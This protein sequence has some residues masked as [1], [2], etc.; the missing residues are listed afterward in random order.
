M[1]WAVRRARAD[2]CSASHPPTRDS[3]PTAAMSASDKSPAAR[4][5][6]KLPSD[7]QVSMSHCRTSPNTSLALADQALSCAVRI[8]K[9]PE[10]RVRLLTRRLCRE[11]VGAARDCIARACPRACTAVLPSMGALAE[12][13]SDPWQIRD[14]DAGLE[15]QRT[16]SVGRLVDRLNAIS[17]AWATTGFNLL[18]SPSFN[19]GESAVW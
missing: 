19:P 16:L 6:A 8:A 17:P 7:F 9:R 11:S 1:S 18:M 3:S 5:R 4:P 13:P 12:H 14:T 2:I 15:G 10:Q